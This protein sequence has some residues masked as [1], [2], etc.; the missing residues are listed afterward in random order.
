VVLR[1]EALRERLAKL[2]EVVSRLREVAAVTR[3]VFFRDYRHQWLAERGLELA[4]QSVL[5]IG[6]HILAGEFGESATEYEGIVK[7]LGSRGVVSPALAKQL[8]G[9][10]GFRN[11]LVHGYL[12]IDPEKVYAAYSAA[13]ETSPTSRQRYSPGWIAG[14]DQAVARQGTLLA[15]CVPQRSLG[16]SGLKARTRRGGTLAVRRHRT[17][18]RRLGNRAIIESPAA[19]R[20]TRC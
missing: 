9:L 10:G 7:G 11:I 12:G 15:I 5:D 1:V 18:V 16:I 13:R 8:E 6:N 4:A 14:C 20:R 2:E 3:E 17:A 19:R